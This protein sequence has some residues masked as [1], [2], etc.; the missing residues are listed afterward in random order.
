MMPPSPCQ[1]KKQ[2]TLNKTTK[3]IRIR[4]KLSLPL[5]ADIVYKISDS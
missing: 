1:T 5:L 3:E 2:Q 4:E